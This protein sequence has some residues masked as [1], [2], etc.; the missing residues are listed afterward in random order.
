M[1]DPRIIVQRRF[2]TYDFVLI[3]SAEPGNASAL[4]DAFRAHGPVTGEVTARR[5][6]LRSAPGGMAQAL[7][8]RV[9]G[10]FVPSVAGSNVHVRVHPPILVSLVR[11][12]ISLAG[13][14]AI[15][16]QIEVEEILPAVQIAVMILA[17]TW[18]VVREKIDD[19]K[20]MLEAVLPAA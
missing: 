4:L 13:V 14:L 18:L 1:D 2:P 7:A 15:A 12:L 19:A 8:F 20:R 5:F 17:L 9:E 16:D 3:T 6:R 10:S 11:A